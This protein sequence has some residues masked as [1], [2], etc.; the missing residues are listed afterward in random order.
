[1]PDGEGV[2]SM[3]P[4]LARN[5]VVTGDARALVALTLR[6]PDAV[7]P[8]RRA[9]YPNKMPAFAFLSDSDVAAVLTHARRSFG[10]QARPISTEMVSAVRA[11]P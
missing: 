2:P 4:A 3:Q 8:A 5:G 10:N 1:M 6:G 7:L 9:A 11:S